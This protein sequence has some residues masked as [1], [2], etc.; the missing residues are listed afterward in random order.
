MYV[1]NKAGSARHSGFIMRDGG[2]KC[3]KDFA[4]QSRPQV[5]ISSGCRSETGEETFE[6]SLGSSTSPT[7]S[8]NADEVR[9]VS[10]TQL[11]RA[12]TAVKDSHPA[13]AS[14]PF[15]RGVSS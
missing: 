11:T 9:E 8:R 6:Y 2:T 1:Q 3:Y 13:R 5:I 14:L 10:T 4:A 15:H 12:D 7:S